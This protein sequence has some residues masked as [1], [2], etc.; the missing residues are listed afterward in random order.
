MTTAALTL[1]VLLRALCLP[2][3]ARDYAAVADHAAREGLSHEAYLQ[4]LAMQEASDRATRRVERL[5]VESKLPRGKSLATFDASR[6]PPKVR[7]ALA[8]LRDGAFLDQATNVLVFGNPG[9]GKTHLVCGL[10]LELIRH[11]RPVLFAPTFQLVQRLLAAKR[12]LRLAA[13]LKRLDRFEAL[14]LDDLG[15]V[16]QDREEMEV[17]FTLL[18]ERYERRSVLITSNLVFSQWDQIFKDPMTTAAAVDRVVHHAV[19]LELPIPSF[20]AQA[21]T[22][23]RQAVSGGSTMELKRTDEAHVND[24]H[25]HGAPTAP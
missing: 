21:A 14:I 11:R 22:A 13:E 25:T 12:D 4:T 7:A 10:G 9:T 17:L 8:T 20:R 16:Q 18:A 19:I 5:I 2:T 24:E 3:F 23:R 15:Y 1:P 6:V